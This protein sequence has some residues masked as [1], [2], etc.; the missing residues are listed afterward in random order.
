MIVFQDK[1]GDLIKVAGFENIE[2][3]T[4]FLR[5]LKQ[6]CHLSTYIRP[7]WVASLEEKSILSLYHCQW[8]TCLTECTLQ[9]DV[10][11][12]VSFV[13]L[14]LDFAVSDMISWQAH[15]HP[16]QLLL[17]RTLFEH[18]VLS[19]KIVGP[20][21]ASGASTYCRCGPNTSI[22]W[23][24]GLNTQWLTSDPTGYQMFAPEGAA[25]QASLKQLVPTD[26]W[27]KYVL[28]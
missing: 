2:I 10:F 15:I 23:D 19:L 20:E 24:Y 7:V 1:S 25:P 26:R 28:L 4:E 3:G 11:A 8:V 13:L 9:T 17:S 27:M 18:N 12:S 14:L 22:K 16:Q 21:N 5:K 6:P